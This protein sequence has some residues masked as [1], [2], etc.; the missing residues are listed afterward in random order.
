MKWII[1]SLM[2]VFSMAMAKKTHRE[3]GTHQHG[4][5]DV[6]IA[7]E[8][9]K[10]YVQF[11]GASDGILGFEHEA[12]TMSD[13]KAIQEIIPKFETQISHMVQFEPEAGC[14]FTKNSI[15]IEK[16]KKNSSH[17]EFLAK[18]EVT[19]EK[20]LKGTTLVLDFSS[21]EKLNQVDAIVLIDDLQLKSEIKTKKITLELK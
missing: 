13:K 15:G 21:L 14:I 8:N 5:A 6:S 1:S 18:F 17:S 4:K 16:E 11:K 9:L 3:H 2:L 19:C 7:F 10:G 12:K 20:P